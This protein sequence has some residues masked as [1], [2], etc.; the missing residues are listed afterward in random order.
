MRIVFEEIGTGQGVCR[1]IQFCGGYGGKLG[2]PWNWRVS[3]L[4]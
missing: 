3:V 4:G 2:A 1:G